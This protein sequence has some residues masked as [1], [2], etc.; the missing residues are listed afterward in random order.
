MA[1]NRF[2]RHPYPFPGVAEAPLSRSYT[3]QH[4]EFDGPRPC[5]SVVTR[6]GLSERPVCVAHKVPR[7]G[8][9]PAGSDHAATVTAAFIRGYRRAATCPTPESLNDSPLP[10]VDRTERRSE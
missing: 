10:S 3:T 5:R 6:G 7:G 1:R 2:P 9:R 4:R 8:W